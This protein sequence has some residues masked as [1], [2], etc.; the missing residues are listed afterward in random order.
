MTTSDST[1]RP[2]RYEGGIVLA[3]DA[4]QTIIAEVT[5]APSNPSRDADGLLIVRAVNA[6][7]ALV[8][9]LEKAAMYVAAARM[10][11]PDELVH[12]AVQEEIA[13]ALRIA[14]GEQ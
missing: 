6:Y 12:R 2:W 7:D 1:P 3:L 5:G 8:I 4:R 10:V 14:R 9:A 13:A 11:K